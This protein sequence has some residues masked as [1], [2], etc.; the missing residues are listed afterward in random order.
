MKARLPKYDPKAKEVL[1]ELYADE[2]AK[3]R[4]EAYEEASFKASTNMILI[5]CA[6]LNTRE[7]DPYG[8]KRL[9][10]YMDDMKDFCI[11]TYQKYDDFAAWKAL[12]IL[13]RKCPRIKWRELLGIEVIGG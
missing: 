6:T 4:Q 1:R 11:D 2:I 7:E 9:M 5:S 3:A 12:Q 13:E 8:E 10:R